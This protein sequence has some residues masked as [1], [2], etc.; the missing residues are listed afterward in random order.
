MHHRSIAIDQSAMKARGDPPG[1]CEPSGRE[2]EVF[3]LAAWHQ[4]DLP[5]C[6]RHQRPDRRAH[7]ER[8]SAAGT[9]VDAGGPDQRSAETNLRCGVA[10]QLKEYV[11]N[12]PQL[13]AGERQLLV[14]SPIRSVDI[15]QNKR[16]TACLRPPFRSFGSLS[17][18]LAH[19]AFHTSCRLLLI[20]SHVCNYV[21]PLL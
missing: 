20:L 3:P 7:R 1:A 4:A 16:V 12:F 17:P 11:R 14:D 8:D 10:D 5:G 21:S 15:G 6:P 13:Q 9:A 18:S 19:R 2:A